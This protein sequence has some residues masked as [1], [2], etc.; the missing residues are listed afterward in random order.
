MKIYVVLGKMEN[1]D[2]KGFIRLYRGMN[3][4]PKFQDILHWSKHRKRRKKYKHFST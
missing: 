3:Y 4:V 1:E 2:S